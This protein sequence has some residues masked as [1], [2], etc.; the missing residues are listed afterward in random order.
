MDVIASFLEGS[1]LSLTI[2]IA[3]LIAITIWWVIV[4]R[5]RS[6]D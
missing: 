3:L 6:R 2:P 1:I 5:R 4:V